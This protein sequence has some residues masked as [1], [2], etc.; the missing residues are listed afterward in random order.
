MSQ[1]YR[2]DDCF[3][4]GFY[5]LYSKGNVKTLGIRTEVSCPHCKGNWSYDTRMISEEFRQAL[6]WFRSSTPPDEPFKLSKWK[7]IDDPKKFWAKLKAEIA[8][9]NIYSLERIEEDVL[10]LQALFEG[11]DF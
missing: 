4:R 1:Y 10:K 5:I 7:T 8:L 11:T 6:R 9:D 3:D 2:C